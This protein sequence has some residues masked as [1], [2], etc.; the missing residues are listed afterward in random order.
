MT[1]IL[2]IYY[3]VTSGLSSSSGTLGGGA[4]PGA[5]GVGIIDVNFEEERDNAY[6]QKV[7]VGDEYGDAIFQGG[8]IPSQQ[9]RGNRARSNT[10]ETERGRTVNK[11]YGYGSVER[12]WTRSRSRAARSAS[13]SSSKGRTAAEPA[14]M[15]K[16]IE[17]LS[18]GAGDSRPMKR[19]ARGGSTSIPPL[20]KGEL[21]PFATKTKLTSNRLFQV[22]LQGQIQAPERWKLLLRFKMK[23]NPSLMLIPPQV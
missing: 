2:I 20:S 9:L 4:V 13:R 18:D 16:V 3:L 21:A 14:C 11:G 23:M 10:G 17:I 7:K 5:R 19:R 12:R 22:V 15:D 6:V 8:A 1:G